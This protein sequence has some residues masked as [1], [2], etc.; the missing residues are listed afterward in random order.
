MVFSL[1]QPTTLIN[2]AASGVRPQLVQNI[3]TFTEK[4]LA[5]NLAGMRSLFL[6]NRRVP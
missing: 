3:G 5:L 2:L 6:E 4:G 1:D